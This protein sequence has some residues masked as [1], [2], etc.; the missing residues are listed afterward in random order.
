MF[1]YK[2]VTCI[3]IVFR[4]LVGNTFMANA[5]RVIDETEHLL[6]ILNQVRVH[7]AVLESDFRDFSIASKNELVAQIAETSPSTIPGRLLARLLF[8]RT[9]EN[10]TDMEKTFIANLNS[11]DP[12]ARKFSL[13]GLQTLEHPNILEFALAALEDNT[14]QVLMAASYILLPRANQD[15]GI[16]QRLR[17]VYTRIQGREAFYLTTNFLKANGIEN[18]LPNV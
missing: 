7:P 4:L 1:L 18:P 12:E 11:P 8:I 3:D 9:D 10:K 17:N 6:E 15:S 2:N 13:Y 16:W 5:N 14:D